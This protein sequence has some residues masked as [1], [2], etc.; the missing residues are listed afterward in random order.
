MSELDNP[1]WSS[2]DGPQRALGTVAGRASRFDPDV[3]PFGAFVDQQPVTSDWHDM[4]SLVGPGGTVAVIGAG[5]GVLDHPD[6]WT[7]TWESPGVQ[8]VAEGGLVDPPSPAPSGGP[9]GPG[10][11]D[12][13]DD[14][15]V[16]LG[17]EDVADMLALV[18]EA[19]PGPFLARTVEFGGYVGIRRQGRLVAMAGERLRPAGWAEVSAVAT[20]PGHRRQGLG[21]RLIR[22]VAS[23]I[24]DR[25][26]TPFLHVAG[27][28]TNAVRLYEALGFTVRRTV[29]FTVLEAPPAAGPD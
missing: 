27:G 6:G 10:G 5:D 23:A 28:N 24:A 19:R 11:P 9:G 18:A 3:S 26:E 2:L 7:V 25:G 17:S 14:P 4:A 12:D 1:V 13:P 15:V 20:H 22:A 29:R 16:A 21:E 8:M